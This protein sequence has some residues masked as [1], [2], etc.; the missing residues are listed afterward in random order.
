MGRGCKVFH[1]I[2]GPKGQLAEGQAYSLVMEQRNKSEVLQFENYAIVSLR[3]YQPL[4]VCMYIYHSW[5]PDLF[6]F[7]YI[8][9]NMSPKNKYEHMTRSRE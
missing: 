9:K 7:I 3:K 5:S 1:N 8:N 4:N 6:A 2:L